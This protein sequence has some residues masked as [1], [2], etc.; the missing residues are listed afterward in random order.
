MSCCATR[1]NSWRS[2]ACRDLHWFWGTFV[3]LIPLKLFLFTDVLPCSLHALFYHKRPILLSQ[4]INVFSTIKLIPIVET[5]N[6]IYSSYMWI[7][8][9]WMIGGCC[10]CVHY[11]QVMTIFNEVLKKIWSRFWN[12]LYPL[13]RSNALKSLP[14]NIDNIRCLY[15]TITDYLVNCHYV[16]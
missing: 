4:N 15:I 12:P 1:I 11:M 9:N 10:S 7:I 5:W 3:A 8:W 2:S 6:T 16:T 13:Y 14:P